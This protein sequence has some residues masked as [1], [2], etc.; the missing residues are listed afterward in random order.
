M[1]PDYDELI[2]QL[3]SGEYESFLSH[4]LATLEAVVGGTELVLEAPF[5]FDPR[6]S[7]WHPPERRFFVQYFANRFRRWP[8]GEAR[9]R[10]GGLRGDRFSFCGR[11]AFVGSD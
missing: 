10:I 9:Q 11:V 2:Q 6:E 5:N 7:Y 8:K 3:D 1:T 4:N